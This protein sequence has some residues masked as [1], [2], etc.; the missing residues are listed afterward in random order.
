VSLRREFVSLA[1]KD[2]ANIAE[3]CRRYRISRETGY[4]WINRFAR[5]GLGGLQ[6]R[7]RRPHSSPN[8]TPG[9]LEEAVLSIRDRH[10]AWGGR[11]IRS[12]M[13]SLGYKKP[14]AAS[15]ITEILRRNDRLVQ[16][17]SV[18]HKP[19]ERF[20]HSAPNRMWQMDFKGHFPM[21]K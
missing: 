11:K 15:T 21:S 19:W 13:I 14:P 6:D 9:R 18:K 4:K 16:E 3:L 8:K 7:C 17:E 5:E 2:E 20:E 12:R 1:S 10:P